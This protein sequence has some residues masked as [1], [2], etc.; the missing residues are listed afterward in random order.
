MN[1]SNI[2]K[3]D[4]HHAKEAS[5]HNSRWLEQFDHLKAYRIIHPKKW[6][7]GKSCYPAR[8]KIGLWCNQ[9]RQSKIKGRLPIDRERL[10]QEIRFPW[11]AHWKWAKQYNHLIE[12][13]KIHPESWPAATCK[14]PANNNLGTWC[15][16]QRMKNSRGTLGSHEVI[17]L[18]Q[19]QFNWN[20]QFQVAFSYTPPKS[21]RPV[22]SRKRKVNCEEGAEKRETVL[23]TTTADAQ[24]P[25]AIGMMVAV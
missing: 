19:I 1:T 13:R 12:W 9:Q 20:N 6:P 4:N 18:N 7:K 23:T 25:M 8:N 16:Y 2:S 24:V 5:L 11:N 15:G 17:L 3:T 10:L 14:W 22:S 21:V